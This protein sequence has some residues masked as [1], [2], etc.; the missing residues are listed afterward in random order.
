MWAFKAFIPAVPDGKLITDTYKVKVKLKEVES[1]K[2][3]DRTL[4]TIYPE[5]K[6]FN[7]PDLS[8]Q[9]RHMQEFSKELYA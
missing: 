9:L 8:V 6:L 5:N 2:K 7:I 1:D 3:C 4:Q